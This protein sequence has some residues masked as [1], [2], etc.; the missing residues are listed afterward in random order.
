MNQQNQKFQIGFILFLG[1]WLV[2]FSG[3]EKESEKLDLAN[4]IP[5][6]IAVYEIAVYENEENLNFDFFNT[7]VEY[8]TN[9]EVLLEN[10]KELKYVDVSH[11]KILN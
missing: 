10:P 4:P 1:W 5:N 9:V 3:L 7:S 8:F 6:E 2:I 11:I